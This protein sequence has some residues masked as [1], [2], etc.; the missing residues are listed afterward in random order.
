MHSMQPFK[1]TRTFFSWFSDQQTKGE[2]VLHGVEKDLREN[3]IRPDEI[4]VTARALCTFCDHPL[5]DSMGSLSI[6][7]K[8]NRT[9]RVHL[10]QNKG[11]LNLLSAPRSSVGKYKPHIQKTHFHFSAPCTLYI[12]WPPLTDSMSSRRSLTGP[13]E[14]ISDKLELIKLL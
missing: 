9:L 10:K 8:L 12:L 4:M 7:E 11:Y 6:F 13:I 1:L 2:S 3:I 14:S 5:T